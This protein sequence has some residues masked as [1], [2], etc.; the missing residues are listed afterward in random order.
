MRS[1]YGTTLSAVQDRQS[2]ALLPTW[3]RRASGEPL[4]RDM[5]EPVPKAVPQGELIQ[6]LARASSPEEVIRLMAERGS[7][8]HLLRPVCLR[9]F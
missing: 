2:G 1:G 8:R 4:V 7:T 5:A 9:P 3:A 6:S